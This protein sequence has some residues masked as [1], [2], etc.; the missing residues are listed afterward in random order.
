MDPK[1]FSREELAQYILNT[2]ND[3]I[4]QKLNLMISSFQ[5]EEI[6]G[7]TVEGKPLTKSE[8]IKEIKQS[9]HRIEQGKYTTHED[10]LNESKNW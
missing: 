4:I 3:E 6:V 1:V 8:Y 2:A 10:L 5:K 7:Y 9:E